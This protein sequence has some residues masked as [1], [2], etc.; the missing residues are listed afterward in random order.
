MF[1]NSTKYALRTIY[2]LARNQG[3]KFTVPELG[4]ELNI[5]K[6]YLSKILQQLSRNEMIS[7]TKGRGG[8]FFLEK[9]NMNKRLLDIIISV[10]G[11]NI[12][13]KCIL[14]LPECSGN[15]PCWLHND[16][17]EFKNSMEL[18]LKNLNLSM[19]KDTDF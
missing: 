3:K 12:F 6:P 5:P 16:F 9:K 15:N 4:N 18:K 7:S 13:D 19:L 17:S 8:G 14:G 11:H 2:F 10:E 1:S